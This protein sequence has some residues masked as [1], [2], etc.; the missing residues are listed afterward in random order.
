MSTLAP[1]RQLSRLKHNSSTSS[2]QSLGKNG[3]KKL[4]AIPKNVQELTKLLETLCGQLDS[5]QEWEKRVDA[6]KTLS[7][8]AKELYQTKEEDNTSTED[9]RALFDIFIENLRTLRLVMNDAVTDLRSAVVREACQSLIELAKMAKGAIAEPL[10]E[11]LL[12]SLVKITPV[13]IAIIAESGASA[14]KALV[15]YVQSIRMVRATAD[16]LNIHG[17]APAARSV[18]AELVWL[19]L[20]HQKPSDIEKCVESFEKA[21]YSGVQ[22]ASA[23]VRSTSR[24]NFW[25]FAKLFP[26]RAQAMVKSLDSGVLKSIGEEKPKDAPFIQL[27]FLDEGNQSISSHSQLHKPRKSISSFGSIGK[28]QTMSHQNDC[29]EQASSTSTGHSTDTTKT[30][31]NRMDPKRHKRIGEVSTPKKSISNLSGNNKIK[32]LRRHSRPPSLSFSP[33][34]DTPTTESQDE[35]TKDSNHSSSV[36]QKNSTKKSISMRKSDIGKLPQRVAIS[37]D[38]SMTDPQS[39]SSHSTVCDDLKR[40]KTHLEDS[41]KG[42]IVPSVTSETGRQVLSHMDVR[43]S[44]ATSETTMDSIWTRRK[45]TESDLRKLFGRIV[46]ATD[47]KV[48]VN[49]LA[50]IERDI[51]LYLATKKQRTNQATHQE[52]ERQKGHKEPETFLEDESLFTENTL[53]LLLQYL[54]PLVGESH[55]K[56]AA[57]SLQL[58]SKV[59]Q[60]FEQ[61]PTDY[62]NKEQQKLAQI[63]EK[64]GTLI[65]RLFQRLSDPNSFVRS[66]SATTI[67]DLGKAIPWIH[68]R[69]SIICKS[70]L[71][72]I[73]S[74]GSNLDS[75][76]R[77]MLHALLH[78]RHSYRSCKEYHKQT[79]HPNLLETESLY[80]TTTSSIS[81][82]GNIAEPGSSPINR[83]STSADAAEF[84]QLI[85]SYIAPLA[86]DK[87]ADLRKAACDVL[88]ELDGLVEP[89]TLLVGATSVEDGKHLNLIRKLGLLDSKNETS[90]CVP[91]EK[92][93][94]QVTDSSPL[95]CSATDHL[96]LSQTPEG[97]SKKK[98]TSKKEVSPDHTSFAAN[99]EVTNKTGNVAHLRQKFL[100]MSISRNCYT[101]QVEEENITNCICELLQKA[102]ESASEKD[103]FG[104]LSQIRD[105][106][107]R[108]H[109]CLN[110]SQ[111]KDILGMFL[112]V[113][114]S[115]DTS[116]P[117]SSSCI[118][119][120][121]EGIEM[122][123]MSEILLRELWKQTPPLVLLNVLEFYIQLWIT[124]DIRETFS[125]TQVA[126]IQVLLQGTESLLKLFFES[127]LVL[128]EVD[129][130]RWSQIITFLVQCVEHSHLDIRKAAVKCL[131]EIQLRIGDL[132]SSLNDT[133]RKLVERYIEISNK[134]IPQ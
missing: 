134:K 82:T 12:V 13:T 68:L 31:K 59:F 41:Y 11:S 80:K 33:L 7:L 108:P 123:W 34:P 130:N 54:S 21:I 64:E 78:L 24:K 90:C 98:E 53:Q 52:E 102:H 8:V 63:L 22:D 38:S 85:I 71:A 28:Q 2:F 121:K 115:N 4:T 111:V 19:S 10:A 57:S 114:F 88:V 127:Q 5:Q 35:T 58:L 9:N 106:L 101:E 86:Y 36:T 47:W 89:A 74:S 119:T 18:V 62:P 75:S 49:I 79:Q 100:D 120:T 133:Q 20:Q 67:E 30:E 55:T 3:K 39:D 77:V 94:L 104:Y 81:M 126:T 110:V 60:T 124:S 40:N 99:G 105:I 122:E 132:N 95:S 87:N 46:A 61:S 65:R 37:N 32:E 112:P 69:S 107:R 131:A 118:Q 76:P 72:P 116:L 1:T 45:V 56:V 84:I 113:H 17:L 15:E 16:V 14:A 128:N 6:L 83:M 73:A 29:T 50:R 51:A 48:K 117:E 44:G 26:T 70:C 43:C 42:S 109:I 23:N 103:R 129:E 96:A 25:L 125:V 92:A 93:T 97:S 91:E 66:S 27:V